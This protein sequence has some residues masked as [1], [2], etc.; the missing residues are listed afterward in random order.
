MKPRYEL[1]EHPSDLAL[2]IYARD[3]RD[4][5]TNAAYA[6]FD[7]LAP[8]CAERLTSALQRHV[9]VAGNDFESLLV[10]WLNELLYLHE[11][12]GELYTRFELYEM[13]PQTLKAVVYGAPSEAAEMIIKA[14]T[15]SEL[16]I[17]QTS[18]GFEVTIVFDV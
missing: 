18:G 12:H 3:L 2:H 17:A 5:F 4:L 15:Y 14:A 16:A 7:Q 13:R 1:L 11:T 9:T 6:M 10:N 8:D